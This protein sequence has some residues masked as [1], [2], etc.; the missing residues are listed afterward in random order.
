MISPDVKLMNTLHHERKKIF[1]LQT[2]VFVFFN[3]PTP[4]L[5]IE[6]VFADTLHV[7]HAFDQF[8]KLIMR[9]N[10]RRCVEFY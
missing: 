4:G 6:A 7:L 5:A 9:V 2:F 3:P 8:E 1:S 10:C